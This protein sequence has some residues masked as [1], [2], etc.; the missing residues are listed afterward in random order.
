MSG[1]AMVTRNLGHRLNLKNKTM[2]KKNI[3]I[4]ITGKDYGC[5]GLS[6]DEIDAALDERLAVVEALGLVGGG[7]LLG[8]EGDLEVYFSA[9]REDNR[10][11]T[12][13]GWLEFAET[14]RDAFPTF[15]GHIYLADLDHVT[16]EDNKAINA[17]LNPPLP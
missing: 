11:V 3:G 1:A 6:E 16:S 5:L 7:S 8:A 13:A 4:Y 10:A 17:F 2:K 15:D 9:S 12:I 14:Y